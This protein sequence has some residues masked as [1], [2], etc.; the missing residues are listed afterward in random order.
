M[1]LALVSLGCSKN[2]VD[3][4][5]LVSKLKACGVE[6]VGSVEEADTVIVN[7]CGFIEEAKRESVET[8]IEL[9]G[10]GKRV[11][12]MGCLVERYRRELEEEL[13]EAQALFGVN[14]WDE[15]IKYLG[16]EPPTQ[17]VKRWVSTPKSYTYLKIAEGCNRLCSFCSIPQIRGRHISRRI[18]DLIEEAKHLAS[19]GVKEIN[20]VSQ[21]T[22]YYG[23]DLYGK[24]YLIKLLEEL[25]KVEGI[26]WIRLLYLYP[27]EVSLELIEFI[28]GSEK[29]LPYFDIPFQHVSDKVLKSM[30]RGYGEKFVRGLIDRIHTRV[31]DAVIRSTLIVGYPTEG[32]EDFD[33]L[34][35][36]VEEGYIHWLGVFTYS[37]E[38]GTHA[39]SLKDSVSQ[40][41]KLRRQEEVL[42]VQR[43]ITE[44]K[45]ESFL[46]KELQVLID[47][48][49]EEFP[50]PLGRSYAQAPE[51]DG[52][53]YVQSEE[54]VREGEMLQIKVD[55]VE[56]YDLVGSVVNN[57][58][59]TAY[60]KFK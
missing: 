18:E 6:L 40:E 37:H 2:L 1:K 41:E 13:H 23:R 22:T 52:V 9:A 38:E 43:K 35:S 51:V 59:L 46:G 42:R 10:S 32:K 26:R 14:S 55:R 39:F 31:P 57:P 7:T 58:R 44:K 25:E 45:N 24:G 27:T 56:G 54:P 60:K 49:S 53:I 19:L 15:V 12:A 28:A 5:I 30:R 21:D 11:V 50:V 36:F 8:I 47:G 34:L 17:K 4:E 29:V 48:F 20:V 16:F 33:K 3:S